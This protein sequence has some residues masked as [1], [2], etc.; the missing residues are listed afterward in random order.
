MVARFAI[1]AP[2][3]DA[4]VAGQDTVRP[5][6]GG[7]TAVTARPQEVQA[8]VH[9][10]VVDV[11]TGHLIYVIEEQLIL[12]LAAHITQ[13]ERGVAKDLLL[14]AEVPLPR[15]R[16][17]CIRIA[18]ARSKPRTDAEAAVAGLDVGVELSDPALDATEGRVVGEGE[19]AAQAL[20]QEE[21]SEARAQ[22]CLA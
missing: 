3:D 8:V 15:I 12:A 2:D 21:A 1:V 19:T 17:H 14:E 11:P 7:E 18:S 16:H 22:G 6:R 4:V 13:L 5:D 20:A 9:A 10:V